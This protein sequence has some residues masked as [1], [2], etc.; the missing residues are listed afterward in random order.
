[1]PAGKTLNHMI[2]DSRRDEYIGRTAQNMEIHVSA[3][4]WAEQEQE[5][6]SIEELQLPSTWENCLDD[7]Q[8]YLMEPQDH[9]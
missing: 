9:V 4:V 7:E 6:V 2:Y 5:G 3:D 8:V 1:M